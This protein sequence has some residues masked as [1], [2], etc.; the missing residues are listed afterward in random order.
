M[1]LNSIVCFYDG[2]WIREN[3]IF[4]YKGGASRCVVVSKEI[5]YNQLVAKMHKIT[6]TR[7][8]EY[9]IRN[10]VDYPCHSL[11]PFPPTD[12]ID[13]EDVLSFFQVRKE[14]PQCC[15][16]LFVEKVRC[17][18]DVQE[19]SLPFVQEISTYEER[20]GNYNDMT[21]EDDDDDY[22]NLIGDASIDDIGE[23]NILDEDI[24]VR[25][26]AMEMGCANIASPI[27]R[28]DT[29]CASPTPLTHNPPTGPFVPSND[30]DDAY[31]N[32]NLSA[33]PD[34]PSSFLFY[35]SRPPKG[36]LFFFSSSF[37][38]SLSLSIYGFD[39]LR[40]FVLYGTGKLRICSEEAMALLLLLLLAVSVVTADEDKESSTFLLADRL[41]KGGV[42][43]IWGTSGASTGSSSLLL[44]KHEKR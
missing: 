39:C 31:V 13:N 10:K 42:C 20:L 32:A 21:V 27:L 30:D 34:D 41:E 25:D 18:P 15:I 43:V 5:T 7:L 37:S 9:D 1:A 12:I 23:V 24:P 36:S 19:K 11:Q 8:E 44:P 2:K 6:K 28:V 29:S 35:S 40:V 22:E 17:K 33:Y 26:V 16:P 14:H 4:S 3:E 38:L